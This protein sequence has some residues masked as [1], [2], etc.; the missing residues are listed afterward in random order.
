MENR[1]AWALL[2]RLRRGDAYVVD[3]ASF[4][5]L[6]PWTSGGTARVGTTTSRSSSAPSKSASDPR[7]GEL[8]VRLR[9]RIESRERAPSRR[10]RWDRGD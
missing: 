10:L 5:G 3:P 2:G 8:A 9:I 6:G 4:E 7:A 1:V